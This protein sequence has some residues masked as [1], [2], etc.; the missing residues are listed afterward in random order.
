MY[1]QIETKTADIGPERATELLK[2]NTMPGQRRLRPERINYYAQLM[3]EGKFLI[4]VISLAGLKGQVFLI[5]GQHTLHAIVQSGVTIKVTDHRYK[6]S[7]EK[8]LVELFSYQDNGLPRSELDALRGVSDLLPQRIRGYYNSMLNPTGT[9]LFL[10]DGKTTPNFSRKKVGNFEKI[11][12][13]SKHQDEVELINKYYRLAKETS[14]IRL[15]V[16]I[17]CAILVT[18]R[19]NPD[20]GKFWEAAIVGN[21]PPESGQ[22]KLHHRISSGNFQI[23]GMGKKQKHEHVYGTCMDWYEAWIDGN[24]V[25]KKNTT[26]KRYRE[27]TNGKA[28]VER[29]QPENAGR[30]Q[31]AHQ[32]LT[33]GA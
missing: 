16:G 22:Y 8:D 5:N 4:P 19:H 3:K 23:Q 30:A 10:I 18:H 25:V 28:V 7:T 26:L 11:R 9:A 6:C 32:K 24:D 29:T 31:E 20:A 21:T 12:L 2:H 14:G 33:N 27:V 13:L 15:V 17:I 1:E